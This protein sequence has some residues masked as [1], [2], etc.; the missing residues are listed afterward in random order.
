MNDNENAKENE[1][2]N[3]RKKNIKL[4]VIFLVV[5]VLIFV[6]VYFG[7]SYLQKRNETPS[8]SG[9]VNTTASQSVE[10]T[11]KNPIDFKSLKKKNSE[12]YAY[13]KIDGTKVDYPIV[14]SKT[15]DAFYL[16]HKA[17]DKSW[18]ASGAVYTEAANSKDFNDFVTVIY[19]HNGYSDTFFTTLHY[20]EKEDFFNSHPYFT[21]IPLKEGL[22]IKLFQPLN[23]TTVIYLTALTLTRKNQS[24]S[25][26]IQF[27]TRRQALK[28]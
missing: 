16:R 2:N 20:F 28:M 17:E 19:G 15:D 24:S 1:L 4:I 23:M 11:V 12:I 18:S 6:G 21:F 8:Q 7:G 22:H 25:G 26:R 9:T 5:F 14:Q 3:K 13:I 10:S 27:K